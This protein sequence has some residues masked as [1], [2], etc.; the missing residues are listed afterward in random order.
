M[1]KHNITA[2]CQMIFWIVWWCWFLIQKLKSSSEKLIHAAWVSLITL[3]VCSVINS[4]EELLYYVL[5]VIK[6]ICRNKIETNQNVFFFS[7]KP[8]RFLIVTRKIVD[9][10]LLI[11]DQKESWNTNKLKW[12]QNCKFEYC[13]SQFDWFVLENV[14]WRHRTLFDRCDA[15]IVF[16]ST[17]VILCWSNEYV[18]QMFGLY[19]EP[20]F[21]QRWPQA[22]CCANE[23]EN[24]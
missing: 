13:T 2:T 23:V 12:F 18:F 6:M 1:A 17:N 16:F 14:Y 8:S 3:K 4:I 20:T 15:I 9:E 22:Q 11:H 5:V 24:H 19:H 10:K 21:R 7:L